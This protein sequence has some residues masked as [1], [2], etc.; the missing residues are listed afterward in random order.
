MGVGMTAGQDPR[1]REHLHAA[2]PQES[3]RSAA[4]QWPK[5]S[6]EL[7]LPDAPLLR[8]GTRVRIS[9]SAL[10]S[11]DL[12]AFSAGCLLAVMHADGMVHGDFQSSNFLFQLDSG[13]TAPFDSSGGR[14]ADFSAFHAAY[15]FL[16]PALTID[17]D[18]LSAMLV[19]YGKALSIR[20][21]SSSFQPEEVFALLG[22][23]VDY[24]VR[25]DPYPGMAA[26]LVRCLDIRL[27]GDH[28]Q[29][30]SVQCRHDGDL[31]RK[32]LGQPRL[33]VALALAMTFLHYDA[34]ALWQ[35]LAER[36]EASASP[37]W[38]LMAEMAR[39]SRLPGLVSPSLDLE[40]EVELARVLI[41]AAA[42]VGAVRGP[43]RTASAEWP[44]GRIEGALPLA[45]WV[46]KF[47]D[48]VDTDDGAIRTNRVF[49]D[50][51]ELVDAIAITWDRDLERRWL[52]QAAAQ[53]SQLL[54]NAFASDQL[55]D[56]RRELAMAARH[57]RL[58]W[59]VSPSLHRTFSG[60]LVAPY[61]I[62][63]LRTLLNLFARTIPPRTSREPIARSGIQWSLAWRG[64][65]LTSELLESYTDDSAQS[66]AESRSIVVEFVFLYRE[67]L[68]QYVLALITAF[69]ARLMVEGDVFTKAF[70]KITEELQ[71]VADIFEG[72]PSR[73]DV[74]RLR[75]AAIEQLRTRLRNP[76]RRSF[77]FDSRLGS[78]IGN[79]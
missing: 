32:L 45:N 22:V 60:E 23:D 72:V 11:M 3:A 29:S 47:L 50:A 53:I 6:D 1:R 62:D 31:E 48:S 26:Q 41:R 58:S 74:I 16:A 66:D 55:I 39:D 24:M 13:C 2:G 43:V 33:A 79:G 59:L 76:G 7:Q 8:P 65:A 63:R 10:R 28:G 67:F 36:L 40:L 19:G 18:S 71:A 20:S 4:R 17:H 37:G 69:G 64:L 61:A 68:R 34:T 49:D 57:A 52:S 51:L 21:H 54:L 73:A 44:V 56:E 25:V 70:A 38:V 5:S 30:V 14:P 15:D 9:E 78:L 12:A 42:D 27:G 46:R 77:L 75:W 35:H